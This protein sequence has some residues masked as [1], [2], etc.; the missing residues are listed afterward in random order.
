ML[1][2]FGA[3]KGSCKKA[4]QAASSVLMGVVVRSTNTTTLGDCGEVSMYLCS[5]CITSIATVDV[6]E[7]SSS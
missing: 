4:F 6:E 1:T 7:Y 5:F 3:L 2:A